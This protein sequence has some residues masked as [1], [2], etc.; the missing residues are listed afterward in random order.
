MQKRLE[1]ILLKEKNIKILREKL[2]DYHPYDL[3]LEFISLSKE[4]RMRMYQIL[5][6]S[7]MADIFEYIEDKTPY[8]DEMSDEYT[9]NVID[10]MEVDDAADMLSDLEDQDK[11]LYLEMMPKESRDELKELISYSDNEAGSIMTTNF[12]EI[13]GEMDVKDA[14]KKLISEATETETIDPLFVTKKGKL[15]GILSLK[16]LVV[17]RT[18]NKIEDIMDKQYSFIVDTDLAMEAS[19]MIQDY[20][21]FALPVVD[22]ENIL[23]GIITID[24]AI[25]VIEDESNE[26]YA[27]MASLSDD[28]TDNSIFESLKKRIPWLLVLSV[29]SFI[30]S[31]VM[32]QF[33]GI[34]ESVTV[35]VFF[36]T[37][38]LDMSGNAGTQALAVTV[39]GISKGSYETKKDVILHVLREIRVGFI[40]GIVLGSFA[41]VVTLLFLLINQYS[42][43][44]IYMVSLVVG[45][46][47]MCVLLIS[48]LSG[49]LLPL[50]F[51]KIHIDPAVASGPFIST[52]SD[53]IS[54]LVYFS[55]ATIMLLSL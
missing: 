7:E 12:L 27:K 52:L 25:D 55:I 45:L 53:V 2:S 8:I 30:V 3:A 43:N 50:L 13:D 5:D 33:M 21:L 22:S 36:Q 48:N 4:A 31:T 26:D 51:N 18:P 6:A 40:N 41:F 15:I 35:L 19:R 20:G 28:E 9:A 17:A 37:L 38:V 32:S 14:M 16:D 24:D 42:E 29:L 46:S 47:M 1:D 11:S 54:I 49:S 44:N 10:E 39:R 23:K 34:I